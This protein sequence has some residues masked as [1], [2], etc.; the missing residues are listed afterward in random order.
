MKI[1]RWQDGDSYIS[2]FEKGVFVSEN[3][4]K[5]KYP[6]EIERYVSNALK[7]IYECD[8]FGG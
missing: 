8:K 6:N 5:N 4:D 1:Y 7:F 2:Q 3:S